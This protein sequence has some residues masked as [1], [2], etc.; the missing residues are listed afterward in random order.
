MLEVV[1]IEYIRKKHFVEGWSI[2]KISRQLKY[3]RQTVRKALASSQIPKYNLQIPR[4][5]PV[6]D[7]YRDIITTW[8]KNDEHAPPKQRH[9][10]KRIYDRLV[11]EYGSVEHLVGYVRRNTMVPLPNV[12]DMAALNQQLLKWCEQER[13]RHLHQWERER[14]KLRPLPSHPFRC[15]VTRMVKVNKYSLVNYDRIRYS[16][17]CHLVKQ[18][19]RLEAF[20]DRIEVWEHNKLVTTHRRSY[21]RGETVLDLNHYLDILERKPRAVMHAAVVRRLPEI[22]SKARALLIQQEPDSYKEL[23]HILLLHR[24]FSREQVASALE[25]AIEMS[26]LTVSTVRQLISNQL[27]GQASP[28]E[29]PAPLAG[30]LVPIADVNCYD[31]LLEVNA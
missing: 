26:S 8:L 18:T 4:P 7:P 24:E 20:A 23:C 30:H 11:E 12:P 27:V 19:L 6:M 16:V 29:V 25:T 5:S 28:A 2:R 9:T 3:A 15:S 21:V 31:T 14:P 10:A 17:P 22:Y 13:E 1:D